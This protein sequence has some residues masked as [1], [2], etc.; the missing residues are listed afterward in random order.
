MITD[1]ILIRN[2]KSFYQPL[3]LYEYKEGM[4][5]EVTFLMFLYDTP[6]DKKN[7]KKS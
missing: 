6:L 5:T 7:Y 1:Q 4:H 2:E 3:Y